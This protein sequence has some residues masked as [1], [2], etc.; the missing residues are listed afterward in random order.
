MP[1]PQS[2]GGVGPRRRGAA[3]ARAAAPPPRDHRAAAAGGDPAAATTRA[4][5]R[6]VLQ[7]LGLEEYGDVLRRGGVAT[8]QDFAR[9]AA[10]DDL[11]PGLPAHNASALQRGVSLSA[12]TVPNRQEYKTERTGTCPTPKRRMLDEV[13]MQTRI[14]IWLEYAKGALQLIPRLARGSPTQGD[15]RRAEPHPFDED[16]DGMASRA[17]SGDSDE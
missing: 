6:P 11:P 14:E 3:C 13:K 8:E 16:E 2:P 12:L 9:L 10:A 15:E 5:L 1:P 7:G 17:S 4:P